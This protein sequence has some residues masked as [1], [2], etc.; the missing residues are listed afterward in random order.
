M[1]IKNEISSY[2]N[3]SHFDKLKQKKTIIFLLIFKII[4]CTQANIWLNDFGEI[5]SA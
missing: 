4:L 3:K 5:F 1:F 2:V